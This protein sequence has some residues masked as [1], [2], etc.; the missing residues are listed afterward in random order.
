MADLQWDVRVG[1]SPEPAAEAIGRAAHAF[2]AGDR[3]RAEQGYREAQRQP[4][5][6]PASWSNL[7]ALAIGL[8]D[9]DG[10][11]THARRALDLDPGHADAWVNFG[12]ASWMLQQRRDAARAMHQALS[13]SP[14]LEA[15]ALN[16]ARMQQAV[17]QGERALQILRDA[18]GH[19]PGSW[20]LSL[21]QAEQARLQMR[22]DEARGA[23]LQALRGLSA[24]VDLAL[25]GRSGLRPP[26]EADVAAVLH[27]ACAELDAL[28]IDY[29]LTAGTLLA[30]AK[31]G[32]VF[33][34]DKDIDLAL[35]DL[36]PEA[37]ERIRAHFAAHQDYRVFPPPPP[38]SPVT[39]IGL[40]HA[41]SGIGVDLMLPHSGPDG[42]MRNEM[43]WPDQLAS[44]LPAYRIGTFH[45]DGRD[46]PVPEP[47]DGFL[48]AMY[49]SDWREQRRVDAGVE[50]DRCYSDTMLSNPS[51]TRESA[52]RAV[53][54]GLIRLVHALRGQEWAHAVAYCAQLL[55][56]EDLVEVRGLLAKL[57]AAG[58]QGLRFDG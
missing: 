45:W 40:L 35:P 25:P 32:R 41:A 16:Y 30:I 50:Y 44:E 27:A 11:R 53:T 31:D 38:P 29:H 47:L 21:A 4:L 26:A 56:R 58:H 55:A 6:H 15:A 42:R 23:V 57:Q 7:A 33:P 43:G 1:R 36:A 24:A 19:V 18:A 54:L 9:A 5:R 49:G 10:A 14:G 46:W 22:H 34:H 12:V 3:R 39:V 2:D 20:P 37:C 13:L 52:P 48:S 8:G 17:G 28:G 51:R